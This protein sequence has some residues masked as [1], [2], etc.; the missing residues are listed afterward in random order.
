MN[1]RVLKRVIGEANL[2]VISATTLTQAET[3]FRYCE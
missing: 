2:N 1:L 3:I